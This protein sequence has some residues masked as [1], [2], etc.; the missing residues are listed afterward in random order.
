MEAKF[1]CHD[2]VRPESVRYIY[3]GSAMD[4]FSRISDF[5]PN[6]PSQD[7]QAETSAQPQIQPDTNL[8]IANIPKLTIG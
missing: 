5:V 2:G 4:V 1:R 8:G 7:P 3:R 6:I